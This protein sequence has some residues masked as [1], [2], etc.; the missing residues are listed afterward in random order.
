MNKSQLKMAKNNLMLKKLNNVCV[1]MMEDEPVKVDF[2]D[3]PY[4]II[5][6][7][8]LVKKITIYS[9]VENRSGNPYYQN[10]ELDIDI[11]GDRSNLS[12][13]ISAITFEG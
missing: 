11:I 5:H 9:I 8:G 1:C 10:I 12:L 13:P 4:G 2:E 3:Y 7:M 6:G